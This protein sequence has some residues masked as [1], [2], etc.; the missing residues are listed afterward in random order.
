[1]NDLILKHH[2]VKGMKWG[3]RKKDNS[4]RDSDKLA[5]ALS[6]HTQAYAEVESNSKHYYNPYTGNTV[7]VGDQKNRQKS[8]NTKK[9]Y[10]NLKRTLQRKYDSVESKSNVDY[11]TGK[12][13]VTTIL[14]KKG[15]TYISELEATFDPL[16]DEYMKSL[17]N[18]LN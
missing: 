7:M 14:K 3:V 16:S 2:G 11:K 9:Q 15:N 12:A 6:K 13:Y 5:R 10:E 8:V 1:M 17:Y 18:V 4:N